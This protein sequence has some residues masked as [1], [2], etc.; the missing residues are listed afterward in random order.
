MLPAS[1]SSAPGLVRSLL[2]GATEHMGSSKQ[3][4]NMNEY[5]PVNTMLAPNIFSPTED[6]VQ[7]SSPAYYGSL[8]LTTIP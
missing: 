8:G 4:Q 1:R 5:S 3:L 7:C 2:Y 6:T